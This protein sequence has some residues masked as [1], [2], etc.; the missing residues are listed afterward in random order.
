MS[1]AN[2][3]FNSIFAFCAKAGG[4]V[5]ALATTMLLTRL[6]STQD[7][8]SYGLAYAAVMLCSILG[9]LGMGNAILRFAGSYLG[10][11]QFGSARLITKRCVTIGLTALLV[12]SALFVLASPLLSRY[13]SAWP[14]GLI[15]SALVGSWLV[16]TGAVL[17]LTSGLR[18]YGKI[19][20]GAL[21]EITAPRL[22]LLTIV[23]ILFV[24]KVDSLTPVLAA[25]T[26]VMLATAAWSYFA[27]CAAYSD[28]V[29]DS[30]SGALPAP[31]SDSEI[32]RFSLP[33]LGSN[34]LFQFTTD[35]TLFLVAV[36][37]NQSEVALYVAAHRI[38]GF[39]GMPQNAVATAVQGRIAELHAMH[40]RKGLE[41]LV[42]NSANLATAPTLL[43]TAVVCLGAGPIMSLLFTP[44]YANGATP[45]IVLCLAQL[46]FV[47]I[48][49][50]EHLLAMSGRQEDV[51]YASLAS[52]L[53][54]IGLS[55][56]LILY[57]G[58]LGAALAGGIATIVFKVILAWQ[59][60]RVMGIRSWVGFPADS[61]SPD[62]AIPSLNGV[63]I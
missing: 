41:E 8:A 27:L 53:V 22:A 1:S 49:P 63:D 46:V 2:Y 60:Y 4:A 21:A 29:E 56:T 62:P 42:R 17:L 5:A 7:F 36:F 37:C 11:G 34:V 19:G 10:S 55:C 57:W 30:A 15:N 24:A 13:L 50:A 31:K 20:M 3:K 18:A 44:E 52:V 39:F 45:L 35:S 40:D 33:L 38:W 23:A 28:T 47:M 54:A 25:A 12:I 61:S 58:P 6:L 9:S 14:P 43:I 32:M 48:G 59:A 51:L 26:V 16:G